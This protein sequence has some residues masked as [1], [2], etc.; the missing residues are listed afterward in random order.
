M[1]LYECDWCHAMFDDRAQVASLDITIG[2]VNET[3]HMCGQCA[4]DWL[5]ERFPEDHNVYAEIGTGGKA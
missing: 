2:A 5:A 4:P 3:A 1:R